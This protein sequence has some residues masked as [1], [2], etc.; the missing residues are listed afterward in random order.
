MEKGR[1]WRLAAP[2]F[3]QGREVE[4]EPRSTRMDAK[5]RRRSRACRMGDDQE[6]GKEL[7]AADEEAFLLTMQPFEF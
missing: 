4:I 7:P 6:A 5:G 2:T 1:A 3:R